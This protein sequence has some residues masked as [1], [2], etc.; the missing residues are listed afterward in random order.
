MRP[1]RFGAADRPARGAVC[2]GPHRDGQRPG[3]PSPSVAELRED[4]LLMLPHWNVLRIYG[5]S[6]FAADL[7][8]LIRADKMDMQVMLGVWIAPDDTLAN[9][10][11]IEAAVALAGTYPDLVTSVCVG[12]ETQ[13]DWSAYRC[14]EELLVAALREVRAR[15]AQPVTTADDFKYWILPAS[16]AVAAEIDFITTHAHPL[17][18]GRQLDEALAWLDA[19]VDELQ[20]VHPDRVLVLG[21]TGWAT[22][23]APEGEQAELIKGAVGEAEQASFL[24]QVTPWGAARRL[25]VFWFEAFDENWKGGDH[26]DE[27]EKHWGLYNADRTPKAALAAAPRN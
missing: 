2:Y 17:W 13:V 8:A 7:L 6:G 1:V 22:A 12:N 24:A 23:V 5:S 10:Q 3:G 21:E 15:V 16:R 9:R 25:P 11:E 20:A 4:L 27:V 14:P 19:R 26:P 18:N